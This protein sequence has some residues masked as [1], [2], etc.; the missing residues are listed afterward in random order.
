MP[1]S[2]LPEHLNSPEKW[3]GTDMDTDLFRWTLKIKGWFAFSPRATEW[4]ARWRSIPKL[5]FALRGKGFWRAEHDELGE[6]SGRGHWYW[7]N[8][9]YTEDGWYL[10][11]V[12][13]YCRWHVAVQWPLQVT[14]HVYWREK[15]VPYP[16]NRPTS[17]GIN[18]LLYMYGPT[19]RDTDVVYWIISFFIGGQWK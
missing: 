5:L 17:L 16:P 12:Q 9:I 6:R 15:D 18:K 2:S 3:K 14:A 7:L 19:H 1:W 10:S 13:Y 4:W 11:R 8:P